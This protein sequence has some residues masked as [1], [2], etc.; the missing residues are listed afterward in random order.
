MT[1]ACTTITRKAKPP[2]KVKFSDIGA[3]TLFYTRYNHPDGE[4]MYLRMNRSQSQSG[5]T[6]NAVHFA[7]G[8]TAYISPTATVVPVISMELTTE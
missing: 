2:E 8:R 6:A 3:G 7:T 5:S 4:H 1:H